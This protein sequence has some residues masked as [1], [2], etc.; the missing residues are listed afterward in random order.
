MLD[1]RGRDKNQICNGGRT[2]ENGMRDNYRFI[3]PVRTS[4]FRSVSK[5]ISIPEDLGCRRNWRTCH[6]RRGILDASRKF[7]QKILGCVGHLIGCHS[8]LL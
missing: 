6:S 2:T 7:R 8:I 1:E 5:T 3:L 4:H